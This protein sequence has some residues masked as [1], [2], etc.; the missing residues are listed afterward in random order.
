MT[1]QVL[2]AVTNPYPGGRTR[3]VEIR[4]EDGNLV[5]RT[6]TKEYSLHRGILSAHST[7]PRDILKIPQPQDQ[8]VVEGCPVV[9]VTDSV[10]QWDTPLAVMYGFREYVFV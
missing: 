7:V 9:D 2:R 3:S 10:E 4:F 6:P 5:L 1:A 8:E